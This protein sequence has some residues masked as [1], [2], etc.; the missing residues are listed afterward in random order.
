[1]RLIVFRQDERQLDITEY[2]QLKWSSD[3]LLKWFPIRF[4]WYA[5][6]VKN[7]NWQRVSE[8]SSRVKGAIRDIGAV[9][10]TKILNPPSWRKI[11]WYKTGSDKLQQKLGVFVSVKDTD[12]KPVKIS[13]NAFLD[14]WS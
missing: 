1:M 9:L 11:P 12:I 14:T 10:D 5:G 13:N 3:W 2:Y 8:P 4:A 7:K 6:R